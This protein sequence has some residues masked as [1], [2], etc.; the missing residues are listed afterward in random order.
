MVQVRKNTILQITPYKPGE[1]KAKE[2]TK[3]AKLS[4]NENPLGCSEKVKQAISDSLS[5][6]NRYPDGGSVLLRE[7]LAKKY[8]FPKEQIICG[9]GSD[10]II[11]LIITAFTA[12]GDEIVYAE[13][14]FLMY[15]LYALAHGVM[16][17]VAP[18]TNYTV[19]VKQIL[20]AVTAKTQI[21]FVTNPNNPTGT[22]IDLESLKFLRDNLPAEILLV[23]DAAY[24]EYVMTEDYED[25]FA[26]LRQYDNVIVTR[27]F[28]KIYGL[29]SLRLGYAISS[30]EICDILNRVRGP[31][32][33]NLIAQ[34]AG[35]AALADEDFVEKSRK[36]NQKCQ[37]LYKEK[38]TALSLSYLPTVAN[39]IL[40][41]VG[42]RAKELVEFMQMK[43]INIRNVAAYNLPEFVRVTFGTPE[44]NEKFFNALE[45]FVS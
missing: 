26:L 8:S 42:D 35:S 40:F 23:V 33:V 1:G 24:A 10:E 4:A 5:F 11:N 9:A 45:E 14:G 13:H 15:K 30:S 16:P 38:L 32:N 28:S 2:S 37:E 7:D 29:A 44:E 19:D 34:F 21:V 6:I 18:E 36:Y 17:V 12:P 20:A 27:T 31:F 41:K 39:F 43:H 22:Y 25:G 3:I